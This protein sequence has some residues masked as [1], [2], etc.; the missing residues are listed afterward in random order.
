[1][2]SA[3]RHRGAANTKLGLEK[4][5][6]GNIGHYHGARAGLG[7]SRRWPAPRFTLSR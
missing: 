1:V 4:R 2:A 5:A 7:L 3:H 6:A